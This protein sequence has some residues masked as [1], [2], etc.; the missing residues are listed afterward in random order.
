MQI[1]QTC[2]IHTHPVA[3]CATNYHA[4][5]THSYYSVTANNQQPITLFKY[6]LQQ[7]EDCMS[8]QTTA[9]H[10]Q[11]KVLMS[12]INVY[13]K[14][15]VQIQIGWQSSTTQKPVHKPKS[16]CATNSCKQQNISIHWLAVDKCAPLIVGFSNAKSRHRINIT[17]VT[18]YQ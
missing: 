18:C 11:I 3:N 5:E 12:T 6:I 7:K 2:K 4:T 16:K 10:E 8:T 9:R 15:A 14:W 1:S 13:T 17:K